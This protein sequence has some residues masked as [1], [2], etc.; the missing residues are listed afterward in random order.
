MLYINILLRLDFIPYFLTYIFS[1]KNQF[2]CSLF[3]NNEKKMFTIGTKFSLID[4]TL[5]YYVLYALLKSENV[6]ESKELGIANMYGV[7]FVLLMGSVLAFA[8]GLLE[9]FILIIKQSQAMK[10]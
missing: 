3:S 7:F 5:L 4:L 6:K 2:N 10:V 9:W 8:Y 1:K